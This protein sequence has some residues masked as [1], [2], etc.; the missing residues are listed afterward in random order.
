MSQ[1]GKPQK[2]SRRIV[3]DR[4]TKNQWQCQCGGVVYAAPS[5]SV[6]RCSNG[7]MRCTSCRREARRFNAGFTCG[8]NCEPYAG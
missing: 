8:V 1:D 5:A 7:E 4:P 3:N 6:A 2:V